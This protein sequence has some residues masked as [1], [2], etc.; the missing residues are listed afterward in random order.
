M[1]RASARDD[2][3]FGRVLSRLSGAIVQSSNT[4]QRAFTL[5]RP[6]VHDQ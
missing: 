5:R 3:S 1:A 4:L 2:S 6:R